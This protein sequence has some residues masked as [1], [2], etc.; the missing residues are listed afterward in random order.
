MDQVD[1]STQTLNLWDLAP[2]PPQI[3]DSFDLLPGCPHDTPSCK[4]YNAYPR[5][6]GFP[7]VP[8]PDALQQN[9]DALFV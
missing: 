5:F 2:Y 7:H 8:G 1:F 3:G 9:A 4:V 6:G